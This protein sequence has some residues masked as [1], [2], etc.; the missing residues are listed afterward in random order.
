MCGHGIMTCASGANVE[1]N[2]RNNLGAWS[3]EFCEGD[4]GEDDGF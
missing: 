3:L 2:E 4:V 1:D